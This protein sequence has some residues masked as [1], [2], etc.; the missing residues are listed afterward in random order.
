MLAELWFQICQA[1]THWQLSGMAG[2]RGD[3]G[4]ENRARAFSKG[5]WERRSPESG[6]AHCSQSLRPVHRSMSAECLP[7]KESSPAP[8]D[9]DI[10]P[11]MPYKC[12]GSNQG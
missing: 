10:A 6:M 2:G 1:P 7:G 3:C 11:G 9:V 12:H 8:R 4:N 5:G